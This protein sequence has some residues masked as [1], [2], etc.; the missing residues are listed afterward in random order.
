ME[1]VRVVI[2]DV[3]HGFISVFKG[4]KN[5]V[6]MKPEP[7]RTP[8]P[9]RTEKTVCEMR[10]EQRGIYRK[11]EAPPPAKKT[12]PKIR[13]MQCIAI[14]LGFAA[15]LFYLVKPFCAFF[16]SFIAS[17]LSIPPS[18]SMMISTM[19][20]LPFY[21]ATRI[22]NVFFF[23]DIA[24]ACYRMVGEPR[25]KQFP[26]FSTRIA[27]VIVSLLLELVFMIQTS[28]AS[29]LPYPGVAYTAVFIH[30]SLLNSL[31]S[32]EYFWISSGIQLHTRI[33]RICSRWPY[34]L[35]YGAPL[36]FLMNMYDDVFIQGC[37][38]GAL[39]PFMIVSSYTA[40]FSES[41]LKGYPGKIIRLPIFTPS[42]LVTDKFVQ[43]FSLYLEKRQKEAVLKRSE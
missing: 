28:I 12:D 14:N 24:N 23:S 18:V 1:N 33:N 20:I 32:F 17:F 10:R 39:F 8:P 7:Q 38:F 42:E 6:L 37:I 22:L 34:F 35:G 36:T 29:L 16:Y 41:C 15:L 43:T 13:F 31:Y 2:V 9:E 26:P 25:V 27:D 21:I 5:V 19:G 4:L 11:V 30:T 40:N 3:F